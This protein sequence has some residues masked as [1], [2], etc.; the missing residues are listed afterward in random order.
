MNTFVARTVT[1]GLT[2]DDLS[3][4]AQLDYAADRYGVQLERLSVGKDFNP[5]I[6][7]V[8]RHDIRRNFG[9]LRFSPRPR[10][11]KV[12]RKL[13][14]MAS[15]TYTENGAGRLETR[16]IDGE[17]GIEFQNSDRFLAGINDDYE[18]LR[19]PFTVAP[20]VAIPVGGY[21]F[22]TARAGY[23]FGQQRMLGG[24]V[25]L[26]RG[27]YYDGD[28]TTITISRSR[29]RLTS[30]FAIEPLLSLN[31]VDLPRGSFTAKVLGGRATYT[32][33]PLM[34]ASA[35]VQY[36]SATHG[37]SANVRFRW[38]YRPGS[39]LFVVYNEE[40]G[41]VPVPGSAMRT[42]ALILKVNRLFRP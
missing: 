17:F 14:T 9:L 10:S 23:T 27:G 39:E 21:S 2:G 13:S 4:R 5:E 40:R 16:I 35:F 8:R 20:G 41:T 18:F 33:T 37:V 7:F 42:R 29:A 34:F 19:Q 32:M 30:Q 12:V 24:V 25:L 38:E 6:G 1:E 36:S 3:Y 31:K 15:L 26:E 28:R 22:V 11:A